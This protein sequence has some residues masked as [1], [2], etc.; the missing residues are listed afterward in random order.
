MYVSFPNVLACEALVGRKGTT[1][2]FAGF[3]LAGRS[4]CSGMGKDQT[5]VGEV[6]ACA[7]CCMRVCV[8]VGGRERGGGGGLLGNRRSAWRNHRRR[9]YKYAWQVLLLSFL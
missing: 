9:C 5:R 8:C 7:K 4:F 2:F 3:A 1:C 6:L